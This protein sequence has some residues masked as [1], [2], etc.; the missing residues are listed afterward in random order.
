VEASRDSK[1][2]CAC[3][4]ERK[5]E[6]QVCGRE[7]ESEWVNV[8]VW[9]S[10]Y[11]WESVYVCVLHSVWEREK[12]RVPSMW[13]REWEWVNV[14]V[15]VCVRERRGR[16]DDERKL[17]LSSLNKKVISF[18]KFENYFRKK[19]ENFLWAYYSWNV[20]V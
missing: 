14:C 8:C 7:N 3:E 9:V 6:C 19:V 10:V 12:E 20:G 4:R 1:C 15:F 11:V 13:E 2:V 5:R 18:G 16:E 17:Q